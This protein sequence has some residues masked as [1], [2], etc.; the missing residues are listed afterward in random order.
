MDSRAD[1]EAPRFGS[2][3]FPDSFEPHSYLP[4]R[5]MLES[6]L[7]QSLADS[8]GHGVQWWPDWTWKAGAVCLID[9]DPASGFSHA[10]ADPRRASYAVG[11]QP[12]RGP[13]NHR[14]ECIV[15]EPNW[16]NPLGLPEPKSLADVRAAVN[17][18][19]HALAFALALQA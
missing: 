5:L 14:Q 15:P 18:I 2:Y 7:P 1:V 13:R 19:D 12:R 6:R 10:G 8:L 17:V 16:P 9:R 3:S 4:G 11:W